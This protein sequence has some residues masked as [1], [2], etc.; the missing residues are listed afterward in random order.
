MAPLVVRGDIPPIIRNDEGL[1]EGNL[2]SYLQ[3]IFTYGQNLE[4]PYHNFRHMYYVAW[5]CHEALRFYGD[6]LSLRDGRDLMIA[7]LTHDIDHPGMLGSDD[8][9][10]ERSLRW[11]GAHI[12][13]EDLPHL[14]RITTIVRATQYPP[15]EPSEDLDLLAHIIR[16][17]D[18]SQG[19]SPVWIQQ[20]IF[21]LAR[22]WR[23]KPIDILRI[24]ET[25][26]GSLTFTTE[27]AKERFPQSAIGEKRTEAKELLELLEMKL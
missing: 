14:P 8:L 5:S 13:K 11:L 4:D 1:Y 26:L 3:A 25:F 22:E 18:M 27:W 20:I 2:I 17:A 24:Q 21:G 6:R 12:A 23:K 9:N 7:A 15:V 16:D 10:I 19:L